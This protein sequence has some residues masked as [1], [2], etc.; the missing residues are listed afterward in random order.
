MARELG[1]SWQGNANVI[2]W[3]QVLYEETND[4]Q[5]KWNMTITQQ[6][7]SVRAE[8]Q[9]GQLIDIEPQHFEAEEKFSAGLADIITLTYGLAY[10]RTHQWDKAIEMLRAAD[11]RQGQLY[12][13]LSLFERSREGR[14]PPNDLKT[15]ISAYDAILGT[16]P[17]SRV[18]ATMDPITSAAVLDKAVANASL[19]VFS[20]SKDAVTLL[21]GSVQTLRDALPNLKPTEEPEDRGALQMDLKLATQRLAEAI[22]DS[23]AKQIAGQTEPILSEPTPMIL[24]FGEPDIDSNG[25][26][27]WEETATHCRSVRKS[28][29]SPWF[30][31]NC[32]E[33]FQALAT[34]TNSAKSNDLVKESIQARNAGLL[35]LPQDKFPQTWATWKQSLGNSFVLLWLRGDPKDRRQNLQDAV[36][37]FRASLKIW[38]RDSCPLCWAQGV[39]NLAWAKSLQVEEAKGQEAEEDA[40]EAIKDSADA[41]EIYTQTDFPAAWAKVQV[42]VVGTRSW[43]GEHIGGKEGSAILEQAETD[44]MN[45]LPIQYRT[46]PSG[47]D[48]LSP[49]MHGVLALRASGG[50][51]NNLLLNGLIRAIHARIYFDQLSQPSL[52]TK[53]AYQVELGDALLGP[54]RFVPDAEAKAVFLRHAI[55]AYKRALGSGPKELT[56]DERLETE[57]KIIDAQVRLASLSNNVKA[58]ALLQDSVERSWMLVRTANGTVERAEGNYLLGICLT[59]LAG[60]LSPSEGRKAFREAVSRFDKALDLLK[61]TE[62]HDLRDSISRAR[63]EVVQFLA[64]TESRRR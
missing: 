51:P 48:P 43:L 23:K 50:D 61:D 18:A 39:S 13:G 17:P 47:M 60:K 22:G 49:L 55:P 27:G 3:G 26:E 21:E 54:Q 36:D 34:S 2:L 42:L 4:L 63:S 38:T 58:R 29:Q 52:H 41:Q 31:E 8:N 16:K 25:A 57:K 59:D 64:K 35:R 53:A 5:V 9:S 15:A 56:P 10:Y 19:A 1:E 32:A 6:L 40:T 33:A 46:D 45:L 62:Q 37:A 14:N 12:R 24:S 30:N 11:S 44:Y 20:Q 28:E 7:R